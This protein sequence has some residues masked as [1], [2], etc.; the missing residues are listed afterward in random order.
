MW[1]DN[2]GNPVY[3][4]DLEKYGLT[5]PKLDVPNKPK[6]KEKPP[7]PL[8]GELRHSVPPREPETSNGIPA[9]ESSGGFQPPEQTPQTAGYRRHLWRYAGIAVLI[10]GI[11]G[12]YARSKISKS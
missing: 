8:E 12:L 10:L 6:G 3:N 4:V 1:F 5:M 9:V 7:P 2:D 11:G